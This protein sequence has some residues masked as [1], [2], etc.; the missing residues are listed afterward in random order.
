MVLE[1]IIGATV[2]VSLASLSGIAFFNK[3]ENYLQSLLLFFVS[4]SAGTLLAAAFLDLLPEA[5]ESMPTQTAM[6]FVLGGFVFFFIL[7]KIIHWHH[8]HSTHKEAK[9]E[10]KPL[11][12]LNLVGDGLHNFI[13]GAA[14]AASF[15]A[16]VP[17]GISTTIAVLLHEIPQEIGDYSLLMYAGFK[18]NEAI[19]LNL[20]SAGLAILGAAMFFYFGNLIE[21][22][23]GIMLAFTAG[24]FTYIASTD[25]V[26][27]IHKE[28]DAKKSAVQLAYFLA[29]ILLI[30]ALVAYLPHGE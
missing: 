19:K 7:E 8:H 10:I 13:D 15:M 27:E 2:L 14:I 23:Q 12:Y 26:P 29:G 24:M 17:I 30:W 28:T 11:G 16:G 22:L 4:F 18:K 20:L 6:L 9:A 5:M 25:L 1:L 21:N 3:R